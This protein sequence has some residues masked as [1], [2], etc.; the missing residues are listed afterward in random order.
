M[1][2]RGL[3]HGPG[4]MNGERV[5]G[6]RSSG[7]ALGA[8]YRLVEAIGSGAVGEVWRVDVTATGEQLAAKLLR[9]EHAED[10]AIVERF[11]RE[12][13]VLVALRHPNIVRVRDLVVE[14]SQ[15][16]I[17][18][19]LVTSGSL[20][21]LLATSGPLPAH[22]ALILT[23]ETLDALAA[24]HAQDIVHRDVKPDN[25][26]LG[27]PWQPGLTGAVR[28][29]DFGIASVIAE[30]DRKTTG[31]LGTPQYMA[32]ESISSGRSD[33]PADVYG[34][35][36]MLYELLSGRTPFAGPGTDFTV[37]Y[38]HV[39]SQPP[40]LDV[41]A[42][43]WS[44][45]EK[46]LAKDPAA[47]PGAAEA[48]V[49]LRRLAENLRDLPPL[50]ASEAPG[51]FAEVERPA[52]VV[53]GFS[54]DGRSPGPGAASSDA[55]GGA[56]TGGATPGAVTGDGASGGAT[57]G[58]AASADPA[59][60][61]AVAGAVAPGPDLGEAGSRTTVRPLAR[62]TS[63][64]PSVPEPVPQSRFRR[65]AWLTDRGLL[66]GALGVVLVAA[67][68]VGAVVWLPSALNRSPAP[69]ASTAGATAFQQD[70]ALPT[71]LSTTREARY[72]EAEG[73]VSVTLTYSAQASAL[74]GD[75]LE[76]VPG[77]AKGDGCPPVTWSGDSVT[78]RKNQPSVTGVAATCG[79]DLSGVDVPAGGQAKVTATL[80]LDS[81]ASA[82][83]T[84]LDDFVQRE[85]AATTAAV[86]D[87]SVSGTSYP[88][89]RLQG[90]QVETPARAVSQT[91]LPVTLV[92]V[93]PSGPDT[94]DPLYRSP[95]TGS[96]SEMLVDVSGGE[97]GVRFADGCSG[98]L[99]VSSDGLV[100]TALS[101]AP[102]C[103]VRAVVG[104]FT[105]LTSDPFGITTR[106]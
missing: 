104:N 101:V 27:E 36:V 56:A 61:P 6:S 93:W 63:A 46:L 5:A 21:D 76:V 29:T 91:T 53:R 19:D 15:L 12:R 49:R 23:V 13:S 16:A 82:T 37:A 54:G 62:P 28:V 42:D 57:P 7:E 48:A 68:V 24:A 77:F 52:T 74:G 3:R 1:V 84:A 99:A 35:G 65:P 103:T 66:F 70:R 100:V 34:A 75:L 39:T 8:S 50:A 92:P 2:C 80:H 26:L 40:T 102:N 69:S 25:V 44:M 106:D 90:V 45:L 41:P 81:S 30:R 88:V 95:S 17:V 47:R 33:A 59:A 55:T 64:A 78:A 105:S 87:T 79:W 58:D 72:D 83:E 85:A 71:G 94:L 43:L 73:T 96:P 51:E 97:K 67:V 4:G 32:P 18:M 86:T 20:R 38:R 9:A 89:Q 11:V 98:A 60:D 10:P 31:L 22:D 14:G